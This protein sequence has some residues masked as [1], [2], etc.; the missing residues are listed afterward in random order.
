[1]NLITTDL[2]LDL[3]TI[4]TD[5]QKLT[6]EFLEPEEIKTLFETYKET[7]VMFE[8]LT[9]HTNFVVDCKRI[10]TDEELQFF[11]TQ[12]IQLKLLE[13]Y[14]NINGDQY[15]YKNE[16]IHRDDDL[17]AIITSEGDKYWYRNGLPHRDNDLPA[18]I[19]VSGTQEWYQ[20]GERH[21]DNDL[22]AIIKLNGYQSWYKYG[23]K[24]RDYDLPAMI[25]SNGDQFWYQ[26]GLQHRDNDLP[27][28]IY[29]NGDMVW[30]KNGVSYIP[31][32]YK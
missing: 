9:K 19:F 11:E 22:P 8:E 7:K 28:I 29:S 25:Y 21:R 30:Y 2:S 32:H 5:V 18:V 1:M 23:K 6:M 10:I 31:I 20:N 12:N 24:H 17:P 26:N 16:E 4:S 13:T 3:F 14:E 27:A 15:W